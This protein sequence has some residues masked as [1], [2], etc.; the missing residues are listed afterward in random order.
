MRPEEDTKMIQRLEHL[1]YKNRLK[2]LGLS[3][4]LKKRFLEELPVAF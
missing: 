3:S 2:E 1:S 4:L